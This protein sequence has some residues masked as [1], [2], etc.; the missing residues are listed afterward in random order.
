MN[1]EHQLANLIVAIEIDD[2]LSGKTDGE[3]LFQRLYGAAA[4]EPIP[5]RLLAILRSHCDPAEIA[6]TLAAMQ[7]RVG[8]AVS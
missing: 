4:Q 8:A 3:A 1:P 2:F 7:P 6:D 5:E